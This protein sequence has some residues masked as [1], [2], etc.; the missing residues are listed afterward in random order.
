MNNKII[1]ALLCSIFPVVAV[2]MGKDDPVVTKLVIDQLE[3][4]DSDGAIEDISNE[5]NPWAW[6]AS[7]SIGRDL[8]KLWIKTEG[9]KV[10]GDSEAAEVRALF[11]HAV[12]AYWDVTAGVRYNTVADVE[13]TWLEL[14]AQ[15]LA[16][17]FL[18]T[19]IS[20]FIAEAGQSALRFEVEKE[21]MIT[22]KWVLVPE[23]EASL[24][25]Y[26]DRE[27]GVGSGLSAVEVGMRLMYEVRREFAPYIGFHWERLYGNSADFAREEGHGVSETYLVVG[28]HAWF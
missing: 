11:S 6:D 27:T 15:G 13:E 20:L 22:Q 7:L 25:G 1:A 24:S 2:A 23:F 26:N 14:G 3:V 17:Y 10:G 12:S 4:R 9:E 18:E 19:E 8:N 28:I 16:P 21:L 5:E